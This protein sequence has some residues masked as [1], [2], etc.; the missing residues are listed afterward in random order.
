MSLGYLCLYISS[1]WS[2]QCPYYFLEGSYEYLCWTYSWLYWNMHGWFHS[3]WLWLPWSSLQCSIKEMHWN[4]YLI[5]PWE[6][7]N[8]LMNSGIV[9]GHYIS[10]EGIQ[11]DWNKISMMKRVPIPHNKR[12]VRSFLGMVGYYGRFIKY[13]SKLTSSLFGWLPKDSYFCWTRN[14]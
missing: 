7:V 4:E 12:Y 5:V 8:F 11:I 3:F 1:I 2:V 6:I 10:K 13:F 14:C 9:L